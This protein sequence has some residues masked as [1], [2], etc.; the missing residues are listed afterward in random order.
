[1]ERKCLR[2]SEYHEIVVL[3]SEINSFKYLIITLLF[4]VN[5]IIFAFLFIVRY[6]YLTSSSLVTAFFTAKSK[7]EDR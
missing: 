2:T 1:M 5:T 4:D 3:K 7:K 6:C